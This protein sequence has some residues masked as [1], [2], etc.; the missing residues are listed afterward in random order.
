MSGE[1]NSKVTDRRV[2][3]A[4]VALENGCTREA[5][6]GAA[7]VTRSTFYRWLDDVTFRDAVEKAESLA[8]AKFTAAVAVAV[9]KNWQAAAWWLERRRYQHYARRDQIEMKIDVKAEVRKLAE[10]LGL[11]PAAAL[12]EVEAILGS[13]R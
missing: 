12:D 3:S 13:R 8:E 7:G 4:L 9:P 11:D 2:E 10:E 6:A 5:A 1:R